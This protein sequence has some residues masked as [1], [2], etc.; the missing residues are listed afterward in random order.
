[1]GGDVY[2]AAYW[3]NG[4]L[5]LYPCPAA[6][7][8]LLQPGSRYRLSSLGVACIETPNGQTLYCRCCECV[9]NCGVLPSIP[10]QAGSVLLR[11]GMG[12]QGIHPVRGNPGYEHSALLCIPQSHSRIG[13]LTR[14]RGTSASLICAH[15]GRES[16]DPSE[17]VSLNQLG[18]IPLDLATALT[19]Q[20]A[21]TVRR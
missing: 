19:R 9:S 15:H 21:G 10:P 4:T 2:T 6:R 5:E 3:V 14:D 13:Q 11:A 18:Q 16:P 12:S 20:C 1:M 8:G 17:R 7:Q